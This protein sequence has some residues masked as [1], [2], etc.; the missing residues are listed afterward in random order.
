MMKAQKEVFQY[1]EMNANAAI[2]CGHYDMPLT[3]LPIL[4]RMK[5]PQLVIKTVDDLAK[6]C[7][8]PK[9]EL[10]NHIAWCLMKFSDI[11]DNVEHDQS[12]SC[13]NDAKY[14]LYNLV[15]IAVIT[16]QWDD[17]AVNIVHCTGSTMCRKHTAQRKYTVRL[18]IETTPNI[19]YML[20]PGHI[21]ALLNCH[22]IIKAN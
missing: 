7:T 22:F 1:R 14:I 11:T 5:I 10:H 18:W 9:E 19:H 21:P 6:S 16:F 20:N 13:P 15:L 8:M 3:K 12:F 17:E 2:Q 4:G